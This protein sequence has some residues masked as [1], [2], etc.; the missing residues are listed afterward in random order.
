M[1]CVLDISKNITAGTE[2]VIEQLVKYRNQFVFSEEFFEAGF[3]DF[4]QL[5]NE[6]MNYFRVMKIAFIFVM[7]RNS[8]SFVKNIQ[9][10]P[11]LP[12]EWINSD[13]PANG[14]HKFIEF[15]KKMVTQFELFGQ[16]N[17]TTCT[18]LREKPKILPIKHN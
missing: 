17:K 1:K 8:Q 12:L 10:I 7:T 6:A 15:K 3:Y 18:F 14:L 16:S 13:Y 5:K 4:Y 2:F 11:A 9:L